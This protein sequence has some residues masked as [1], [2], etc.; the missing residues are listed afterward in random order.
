MM[1]EFA[2]IVGIATSQLPGG[3]GVYFMKILSPI[4]KPM[5]DFELDQV[6]AG[7]CRNCA[8][9]AQSFLPNVIRQRS[10]KF[11]LPLVFN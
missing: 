1:T 3:A 10:P 8:Y 11:F 9:I 5:Y 7:I 4:V 2:L 6:V